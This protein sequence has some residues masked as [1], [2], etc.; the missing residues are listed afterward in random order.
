[1]VTKLSSLTAL[2][3]VLLLLNAY[4]SKY[5][6]KY[7]LY[8]TYDILQRYRQGNIYMYIA[9]WSLLVRNHIQHSCI[10]LPIAKVY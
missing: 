8:P 5:M 6:S 3:N 1:M 7:M 10:I 9:L 2:S 4:M